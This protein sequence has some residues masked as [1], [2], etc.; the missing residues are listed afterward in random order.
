MKAN[1]TRGQL[2]AALLAGLFGHLLIAIGW[3][4]F[5]M[6]VVAALVVLVIGTLLSLLLG[7]SNPIE[8]LGDGADDLGVVV[9]VLVVVAVLVGAAVLVG[10]VFLSRGILRRGLVRRPVAVTIRAALIA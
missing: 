10:G 6:L 8:L 4:S 1:L 5:G 3:W 2:V 7:G 9:V